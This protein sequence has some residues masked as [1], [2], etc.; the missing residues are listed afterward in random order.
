M[1]G[2]YGREG[3]ILPLI[4]GCE[5]WICLSVGVLDIAKVVG[6]FFTDVYDFVITLLCSCSRSYRLKYVISE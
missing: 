2:I 3:G 6:A 1:Q 4:L 5:M